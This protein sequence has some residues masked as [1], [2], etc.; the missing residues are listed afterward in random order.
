MTGLIRNRAKAGMTIPAAPRMTSASLRPEVLKSRAPSCLYA[1]LRRDCQPRWPS[2]ITDL[3]IVGGGPA[4]M[5]A[6]LL[7][8]RAGVKTLVLEKHGDFLRDFRGDTVHPSTLELFDELGLLD[9]SW[10]GRTTRSATLTGADR[11]RAHRRSPISAICRSRCA[12]H[13]DDAAVGVPRFRRA[14]RRAAYPGF[15]LRMERRGD[16]LRRGGRPGRR[17]AARRRRAR[18]AP[19]GWCIAADGRG[20][21]VRG[22][23]CCRCATSARRWTCS[24]SACPRR[25]RRR[26]RAA[27]HG[28]RRAASRADRPRRLLAMRLRHPQGRGRR[29]PGARHRRV[30]RRGRRRG[31]RSSPTSRDARRAG[32]TSN[33]CRSSLD[34]LEHWHRP[35]LLAIG[36][37]AHA[38]SPI[39]GVG[40]NSPSRTR[41]PRPISWPGRWP[42]ARDVDRSA[43]RRCSAGAC[44][45][46]RVDPGACRRRRRTAS[47][48]GC[49]CVGKADRHGAARRCACSTAFPLL[50]RIPGA[51]DRPR[52]PARACPLARCRAQAG[53]AS[54]RHRRLE[55]DHGSP[56]RTAR[57]SSSSARGRSGWRGPWSSCRCSTV[58]MQTRSS[59]SA[60]RVTS[61]VSSN[62][63]RIL[64]AAGPGEDRG[65]RVGRGRLALLVHAVV[66]GDG[67]VRG[68]GLDRLAVRASSGSRSSGRAS[69]SPAR[70][71]P[72]GRRRR[73]SCRPRRTCRST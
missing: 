61:G 19:A 33:C 68:L 70:P 49:S 12:V 3:L 20:S 65:D 17:R 26:R 10:S 8:A 9:A 21:L 29:G 35:G 1:G 14:T 71:G 16:G 31:R 23:R 28:R 22:R 53:W 57:W 47:S 15:A 51:H 2:E 36:D 43:R 66:A 34:R 25:E 55:I 69:R 18:S 60:K 5:M 24:G 62:L 48:A 40:I 64:E 73:N 39:G 30:P 41:S 11:R 42:R 4:G 54:G 38:M 72:T 56:R 13:R 7:F 50:R 59:V 32:T 46:T 67:A 27:R 58:S 52:R 6:G 63:P 45:P 44:F 37:A